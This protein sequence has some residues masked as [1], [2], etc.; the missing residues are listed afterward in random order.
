MQ[1]LFD[2]ILTVQQQALTC[3]GEGTGGRDVVELEHH[4]YTH[5]V[6]N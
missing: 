3:E 4:L 6:T 1:L 5:V 2:M